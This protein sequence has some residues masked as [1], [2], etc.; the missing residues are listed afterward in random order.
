MEKINTDDKQ[1]TWKIWAKLFK[2][3]KPWRSS[4]KYLFILTEWLLQSWV[5]FRISPLPSNTAPFSTPTLVAWDTLW[6]TLPVQDQSCLETRTLE[7]H[8]PIK[9]KYLKHKHSIGETKENSRK[10][11]CW[12]YIFYKLL[13]FRSQHDN[14]K[15]RYEII[16]LWNWDVLQNLF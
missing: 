8:S 12:E 13:R 6:N 5:T 4:F 16:Y 1:R 9:P 2:M 10:A 3:R 11:D 14:G 7:R 15:S